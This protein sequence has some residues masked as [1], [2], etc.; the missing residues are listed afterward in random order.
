MTCWALGSDSCPS[1]LIPM[2]HAT[3]CLDTSALWTS[4]PAYLHG[5]WLSTV[6]NAPLCFPVQISEKTSQERERSGCG[7]VGGGGGCSTVGAAGGG[8][9]SVDR[10]RTSPSQRLMSTHHHHHHLGYSLL[11]AQYNLPYA[12]GES[13]GPAGRE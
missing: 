7:V 4:G 12:T 3:P 5:A 13:R 8:E 10:P 6:F 1:S 2:A 9:R 11:P